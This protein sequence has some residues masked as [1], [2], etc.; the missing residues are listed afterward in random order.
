MIDN[1][2]PQGSLPADAK[3]AAPKRARDSKHP[4]YRGVRMRSWGKWVSEIREP[5][6]KSRI[7][8]GTFPNPEMAARAHDV[9]A[10][11]IKGPSAILNFPDLAHSLP[12][13]AS[14]APRDVQAAAAKAAAA[15]PSALLP[16]SSDPSSCGSDQD[17]DLCEIVELPRLDAGAFD[18]AEPCAEPYFAY[19]EPYYPP[20]SVTEDAS[21]YFFNLPEAFYQDTETQ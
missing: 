14:L 11:S 10:M 17:H 9:A 16:S 12:R 7:W 8:L 15:D 6:K 13:P 21:D 3:A 5:R 20:W 2:E 18:W 4:A 1:A 19:H